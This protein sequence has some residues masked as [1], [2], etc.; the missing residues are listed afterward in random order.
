M[1]LRMLGNTHGLGHRDTDEMR[2]KK[3]ESRIGKK[4]SQETLDKIG[5]S[6]KKP[7]TCSN[8]MTFDS[9]RAAIG[10]LKFIGHLKA[11]PAA[12]SRCCL[13]T[14]YIAYGFG[15][16]FTLNVIKPVETLCHEM[17]NDGLIAA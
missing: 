15:W 7:V 2:K 13:G 17:Y 11:A 5:N 12:I 4:H 1:A 6:H 3:S 16:C 10:W 9:I 14:A 8:G